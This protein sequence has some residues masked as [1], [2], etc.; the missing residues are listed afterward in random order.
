MMTDLRSC[1]Y[2]QTAAS[3]GQRPDTGGGGGG[4]MLDISRTPYYD[5]MSYNAAMERGQYDA[6]AAAASYRGMLPAY[7]TPHQYGAD[8]HT[9]LAAGRH[10]PITSPPSPATSCGDSD[11]AG[12]VK[13]EGGRLDCCSPTSSGDAD[14]SPGS[15][16]HGHKDDCSSGGDEN[17]DHVPHILA[18]GLHGPTRRCLLWACKACKKKTVAVDRRKAATMRERKRLHKV[19]DAFETLK[20]RTCPNPNQRLPKVE[21]LRNAIDYIESLEELLHGSRGPMATHGGNDDS[22]EN[23]STSG[24]SEYMVSARLVSSCLHACPCTCPYCLCLARLVSVVTESLRYGQTCTLVA[25]D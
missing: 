25:F 21:I 23:G 7:Y 20:R 11:G 2:G 8:L 9:R 4:Q 13:R 15:T 17:D 12:K 5:Q 19:N 22:A 10:K 6:Y 1:R 3:Y 16:I 24:G 18:P 14:S